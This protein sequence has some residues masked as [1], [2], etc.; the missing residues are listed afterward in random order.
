M[1]LRN[2]IFMLMI[3][4]NMIKHCLSSFILIMLFGMCGPLVLQ[5]VTFCVQKMDGVLRNPSGHT[6]NAMQQ[7]TRG[8]LK[9]FLGA[10]DGTNRG[11]EKR[12]AYPSL[13]GG[14]VSY[15]TRGEKPAVSIDSILKIVV[16]KTIILSWSMVCSSLGIFTVL[17]A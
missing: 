5:S 4:F 10:G 14:D 15:L 2:I 9:W 11:H 6:N 13:V 17:M 16:S 7:G 12:N 1:K 3:G 8:T